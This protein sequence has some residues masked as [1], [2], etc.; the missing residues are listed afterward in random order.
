MQLKKYEVNSINSVNDTLQNTLSW[1]SSRKLP[2]L[3]VVCYLEA[4]KNKRSSRTWLVHPSSSEPLIE[5]E[6]FWQNQKYISTSPG[7]LWVAVTQDL[8]ERNENYHNWNILVK[9]SFCRRILIWKNICGC[10]LNR[11]NIYRTQQNIPVINADL[12]YIISEN[13]QS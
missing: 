11:Q 13:F 9:C 6:F 12:E 8:K 1:L 5:V 10:S 2:L 7:K 3:M 4:L